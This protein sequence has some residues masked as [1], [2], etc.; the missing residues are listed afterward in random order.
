MQSFA[1]PPDAVTN[2]NYSAN[3]VAGEVVRV[4]TDLGTPV[5]AW[6]CTD[7]HATLMRRFFCHGYAFGTFMNHG[8]TVFSGRELLKVI[9]DEYQALGQIETAAGV[10]ADDVIVFWHGLNPV[11]SALVHTPAFTGG[12]TLDPAAT[13]V[14][15]KYGTGGLNVGQTLQHVIGQYAEANRLEVYRRW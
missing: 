10:L 11:H 2:G 15:S 14:D 6:R 8:Y 13:T 9:A 1:A 3:G 7:P 12:G 4:R 5:E